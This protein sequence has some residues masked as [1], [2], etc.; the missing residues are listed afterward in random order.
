M[1]GRQKYRK[2]KNE[3]AL[4]SENVK[5][6]A[7]ITCSANEKELIS[8]VEEFDLKNIECVRCIRWFHLICTEFD[9]LFVKVTKKISPVYTVLKYFKYIVIFISFYVVL[10]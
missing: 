4:A 9:C 10:Q 5:K 6:E 8:D 7:T 2:I 1:M 3:E